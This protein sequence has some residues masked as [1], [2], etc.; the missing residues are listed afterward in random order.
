M[1]IDVSGLEDACGTSRDVA[2]VGS[3]TEVLRRV[4]IAAGIGW[5]LVFIAIGPL[6]D[7]QTYADGSIFSYAVAVQD[8]WAFHW[9]NIA[10]RLFVYLVSLLPAET[11]VAL[12]RDPHGG[13]VLYGVLFFAAQLGGLVATFAAD[14]SPKRVLFAFACWSTAC[15]CPF[16]FGF[17]TE[18]WMAHAVFW[19]TLALCHYARGVR[20]T[21]AILLALLAL[22]FTYEGGFA[23]A[24]VIMATLALRG[25]WNAALV[26]AAGAFLVAVAIWVGVHVALP[27]DD[28]FAP[29]LARAALHVFDANVFTSDVMLLVF[30][31]LA[32]Y[33]LAFLLVRRFDSTKAHRY[34]A[35]AVLLVLMVYWLRFDH[36]LHA[37][38]RY[39]LRTLLLVAMPVLGVL[40]G[41]SAL[42]A[43]GVLERS[44]PRLFRLVSAL[45]SGAAARAVLGA[46]VLLTVI[47]A[48]ETIKFV[49][50]WT[51]YRSAVRALAMGTASDPALGNSRFVSSVRIGADLNRLA[52]FSTTPFLSVLVAPDFAPERLVIDPKG[53]YFWL[54]CETAA[55]DLAAERAVPADTR[56]LV[57]IYSCLHR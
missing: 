12:T 29:V 28:Y 37:E 38:N 21:V 9:H 47:H 16:V 1:A 45:A 43:D 39:Y 53:N 32:V 23:L 36:A 41:A 27:P 5:S 31:A 8:V 15:L 18:V 22:V 52:W 3:G 57:R 40:A 14:R 56:R 24:L 49:T 20:G 50:A 17:P 54:S 11:Y 30:G 6:Y 44:Y 4:A 51:H 55:D 48:V 26:R 19:P 34:A 25:A 13:I 42:A 2:A 33:G 46:L 10:G 35:A 7:L